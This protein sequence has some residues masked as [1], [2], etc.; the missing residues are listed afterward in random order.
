[1]IAPN[2]ITFEILLSVTAFGD[3]TN[4]DG[5]VTSPTQAH[6]TVKS[7][8]TSTLASPIDSP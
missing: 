1:M 8:R 7:D 6:R 3:N 4:P 5:N 2:L